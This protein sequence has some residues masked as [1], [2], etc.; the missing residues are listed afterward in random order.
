MKRRTFTA[1][2]SQ[3]ATMELADL[4]RSTR[5]KSPVP[6]VT[7]Y[8][9]I[10]TP[11]A[12]AFVAL[13]SATRSGGAPHERPRT[14]AARFDAGELPDFLPET[15]SIRERRMDRG[16]RCR[17]TSRTAASRSPARRTGRWS[18]TR[19]IRG[20]NIFMADFEDSN[21]PTWANMIEGQINLRDAVAAHDRLQSPEGK[22]YK[23]NDKTATL[24]VRPRGWH[25]VEKHIC[26]STASRFPARSSTSACISS[27]TPRR[28]W[29]AAAAPYFYLPK[30]ESHLE[31]RLWNDVFVDAQRTLGI[32]HGTHQG[33]GADRDHARRVRD[34][35]DPLRAARPLR[36]PQLR[37]LGLH[38][39]LHQEIPR[40]PGLLSRRS[41]AGDD[42]GALPARVLRCCS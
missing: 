27:T 36:R 42:D 23:L 31:A 10:L 40:Q 17:A 33:D 29:R 28:C 37:P 34:G 9:D 12:L 4:L 11:Q 41:R 15:R 5:S 22:L 8:S 3:E 38:L 16:D 25:L 20:A 26:A 21:A 14:A 39:Q 6:L 32:P 13:G 19:S 18:S 24:L 2:Y 35:R 30:M 7:A 1:C